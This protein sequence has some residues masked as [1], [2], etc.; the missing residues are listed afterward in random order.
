MSSLKTIPHLTK[1]VL[2]LRRFNFGCGTVHIT[3]AIMLLILALVLSDKFSMSILTT[4]FGI[5]DSSTGTFKV[6]LITISKYSDVWLLVSFEFIT[7]GF[8]YFISSEFYYWTYL[9]NLTVIGKNPLRWFEYTITAGLMIW[10]IVSQS[11]GTNLP[12]KIAILALNVDMN[13]FGFLQEILNKTQ[14]PVNCFKDWLKYIK[15]MFPDSTKNMYIVP[16]IYVTKEYEKYKRS[17]NE[18]VYKGNF[19]D[20]QILMWRYGSKEKIN[21]SN[22]VALIIGF[23]PFLT[24]WGITMTYFFKAVASNAKNVPWWIWTIVIGLFIT[25]TQFAVVM[26]LHYM[27]KDA[28]RK[29]CEGNVKK[30]WASKLSTFFADR[31]NE[32][33]TYQ[34]LSLTNKLFLTW[35]L[36]IG[37]LSK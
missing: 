34:L 32:E 13:L 19:S 30:K 16:N 23:I 22:Y 15:I 7:A 1:D 29:N 14:Y 35:I 2:F 27:Q 24:T 37:S 33:M 12:L 31:I 8:H 4:D 17:V 3:S 28:L 36:A 20:K 21:K 11:F 6:D 5:Y 25:F 10:V 26:I 9:Y 18:N